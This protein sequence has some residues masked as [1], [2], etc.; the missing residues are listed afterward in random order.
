V[1]EKHIPAADAEGNTA[2]VVEITN[3]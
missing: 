1:E 3:R 2:L